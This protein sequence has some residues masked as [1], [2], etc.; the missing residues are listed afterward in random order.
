MQF[1]S[2]LFFDFGKWFLSERPTLLEEINTSCMAAYTVK[3]ANA[4]RLY[5]IPCY[6]SSRHCDAYCLEKGIVCLKTIYM[7]SFKRTIYC[8]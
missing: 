4:S 5:G 6:N 7:I 8:S 2:I 3:E 1:Y